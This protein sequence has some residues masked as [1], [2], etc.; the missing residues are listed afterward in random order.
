MDG[1][2]VTNKNQLLIFIKDTTLYC[3]VYHNDELVHTFPI[4]EDVQ[5]EKL[6]EY[7]DELIKEFKEPIDSSIMVIKHNTLKF[8]QISTPHMKDKDLYKFIGRKIENRKEKCQWSLLQI[9]SKDSNKNEYLLYTIDQFVINQFIS[10]CRN[11]QIAPKGALPLISLSINSNNDSN[12]VEVTV[13]AFSSQ[14]VIIAVTDKIIFTRQFTSFVER[15]EE[16]EYKRL[17]Q[18]IERTQ[19]YVKQQYAKSIDTIIFLGNVVKDYYEIFQN[20]SHTPTVFGG[21]LEERVFSTI[22]NRDIEK[23]NSINLLPTDYILEPQRKRFYAISA[24]STVLLFLLLL[25]TLIGIN[26]FVKDVSKQVNLHQLERDTRLAEERQDSLLAVVNR[27]GKFS[28]Y[29][30]LIESTYI[31]PIGGWMMNGIANILPPELTLTNIDINIPF[32][33]ENHILISGLCS[34]NPV[35]SAEI[36]DTFESRLK[37]PPTSLNIT[38]VWFEQWYNNLLSGSTLEPDTLHKKFNIE[39]NL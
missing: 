30:D 1:S 26:S 39:G 32:R 14:V 31:P 16:I 35:K 28:S 21:S 19:L 9:A 6:S 18:E 10:F 2:I 17:T 24:V 11:W 3:R 29:K 38:T 25:I 5:I 7:L 15:G 20:Q 34:R 33:G 13:A 12:N 36:L 27:Y 4:V 8:E 23:F 37:E 22:S